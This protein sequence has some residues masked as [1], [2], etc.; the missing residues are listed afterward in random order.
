LPKKFLT[1]A[2]PRRPD[3]RRWCLVVD[4]LPEGALLAVR[5]GRPRP[6]RFEF[7]AEPSRRQLSIG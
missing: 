7:D 5:A 2:L 1:V 3:L 4:P 6:W